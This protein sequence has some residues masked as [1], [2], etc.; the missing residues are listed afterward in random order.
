[1]ARRY[2]PWY[3]F[4]IWLARTVLF[5]LTGGIRVVGQE[6]VPFTG[7]LIVAPNHSSNLDPEAAAVCVGR[8]ITF[9]AKAQLF[10]VPV[11][12]QLIR[13]LGAFPVHR[14]TAD[15]EAL[16]LT[17]RLLGEGRAVLVFPEGTRGDGKQLLPVSRGIAM[18]AKRSGAPVLPVAIIGNHKKMPKG[19][20]WIGWGRTIVAFAKPLRFE[21]FQEGRS[22]KEAGEALARAWCAEIVRL[23]REQGAKIEMPETAA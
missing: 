15:T 19:R 10:K 22:E 13:S 2:K 18:I 7:P 5:K 6:N 16:R 12:G 11:L 20:P 3:G 21:D 4:I 14:G 1:M 9:M 17:Y 8:Q 23:F